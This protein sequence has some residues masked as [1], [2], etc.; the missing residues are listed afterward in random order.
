[1]GNLFGG[2]IN[3]SSKSIQ[4]FP[5]YESVEL[6]QDVETERRMIGKLNFVTAEDEVAE[7]TLLVGE[8]GALK[9]QV[10]GELDDL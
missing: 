9:A 6:H 2:I 7:V 5:L 8:A 10:V 4:F 3:F 1:M